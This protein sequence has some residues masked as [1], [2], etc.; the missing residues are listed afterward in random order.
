MTGACLPRR[1]RIT[2]NLLRQLTYKPKGCCTPLLCNM[3]TREI[4]RPLHMRASPSPRPG[5]LPNNLTTV[6]HAELPFTI[7]IIVEV[8]SRLSS[9]ESSEVFL[10]H[11]ERNTCIMASSTADLNFLTQ[12]QSAWNEPDVVAPSVIS[13]TPFETSGH[14]SITSPWSFQEVILTTAPPSHRSDE[15]IERSENRCQSELDYDLSFPRAESLN[16]RASQNEIKANRAAEEHSPPLNDDPM[17]KLY[18]T[19]D[20]LLFEGHRLAI[21]H[22]AFNDRYLNRS[23]TPYSEL[24][25]AEH[26]VMVIGD[27]SD[28]EEH[29]AGESL[30]KADTSSKPAKGMFFPTI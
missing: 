8:I 25:T 24:S 7:I 23:D 3:S 9:H 22:Q 17:G 26:I 11:R 2:L 18:A 13:E 27:D 5:Q 14:H 10:Q 30:G 29:S 19:V 12:E 20:E 15:Q 1:D 4:T 16:A 28:L 21:I 6:S